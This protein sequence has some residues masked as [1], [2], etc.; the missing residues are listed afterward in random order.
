MIKA[1]DATDLCPDISDIF[2][3]TLFNPFLC[4]EQCTIIV[5]NTLAFIH[6]LRLH[7][8]SAALASIT[9][10]TRRYL[11]GIR[12]QISFRR[13]MSELNTL[14]SSQVCQWEYSYLRWSSYLHL[15]LITTSLIRDES[16][17]GHGCLI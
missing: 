7:A 1:W 12:C 11:L 15:G 10:L 2:C 13:S 17:S 6:A 3:S 9:A 14:T 4:W 8:G 5:Y 16:D